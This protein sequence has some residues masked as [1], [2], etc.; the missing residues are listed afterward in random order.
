M[1][2]QEAISK[3]R[4]YHPNTKQYM[5][6]EAFEIICRN[7]E[8]A[9]HLSA[10]TPGRGLFTSENALSILGASLYHVIY[11]IAKNLTITCKKIAF[12]TETLDPSQKFRQ[13]WQVEIDTKSLTFTITSIRSN[14]YK[15][16]TLLFFRNDDSIFKT[17]IDEIIGV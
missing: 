3:F 11:S 14:K 16:G 7:A 1:T 12:I 15:P 13:T 10:S 9:Q 8:L 2:L 17:T 5:W 4:E 6:G